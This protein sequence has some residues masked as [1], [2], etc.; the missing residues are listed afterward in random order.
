MRRAGSGSPVVAGSGTLAMVSSVTTGTS[1]TPKGAV[2]L[3]GGTGVANLYMA[4]S[5]TNMLAQYSM[6][7]GGAL[8]PFTTRDITTTYSGPAYAAAS[9]DGTS[10]YVTCAGSYAVAYWQRNTSTGVLTSGTGLHYDT[11][12]DGSSTYGGQYPQGICLS[13]DGAFIYTAC[14]YIGGMGTVC[15]M[16]RNVSTGAV[17]MLSP[18]KLD[19]GSGYQPMGIAITQKDSGAFVFVAN[20]NQST[21][22]MF[23]RNTTTGLLTANSVS[24]SIS[25]GASSQCSHMAIGFNA[26]Q[27]ADAHLYVALD[28]TA[29]VGAYTINGDGT[30]TLIAKYATGNGPFS[31]AISS[32]GL[33]VYVGNSD[34]Q[35]IS[36]Y[37]RTIS[38]GTLVAKTPAKVRSDPLFTAVTN[39]AGPQTL[40][41]SPTVNML[42]ATGTIGACSIAQFRINP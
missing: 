35:D 3:S 11:G 34:G 14:R 22:S 28:G 19:I 23:T 4:L 5:T 41:Y 27:T 10:I 32:D 17:A 13:P 2:A 42:Y 8:T 15:Q 20:F 36:Q 12:T 21:I 16:S 1:S 29:Q 33:S 37:T 39:S 26:A 24:A 25:T 40:T 7:S 6:D 38:D 30:L 18:P 31:V 9:A